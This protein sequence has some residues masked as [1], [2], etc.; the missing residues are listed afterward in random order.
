M[1]PPMFL[2][3]YACMYSTRKQTNGGQTDVQFVGIQLAT[4]FVLYT[5]AIGFV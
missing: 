1:M 5:T 3:L 2:C 4:K